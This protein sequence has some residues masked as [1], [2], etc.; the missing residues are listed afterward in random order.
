MISHIDKS[1]VISVKSI[2]DT[3]SHGIENRSQLDDVSVNIAYFK[4]YEEK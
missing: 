4:R 1:N 3:V 2:Q